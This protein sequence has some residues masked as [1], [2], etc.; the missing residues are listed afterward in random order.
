MLAPSSPTSVVTRPSVHGPIVELDPERR[1]PPTAD[2][3][4]K[5]HRSELA[6]VDVAATQDDGDATAG[7][8]V[9]ASEQ[10]SEGEGPGSLGDGLLDL[11]VQPDRLLDQCLGHELDTIDA[12]AND[13]D[14]VSTPEAEAEWWAGPAQ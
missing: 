14:G 6:H 8:D 10:F 9:G 12:L 2:Q 11:E 1:H 7:V 13:L 3:L 4:A 5:V